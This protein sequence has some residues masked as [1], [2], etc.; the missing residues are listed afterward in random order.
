MVGPVRW[1]P[2]AVACGWGAWCPGGLR[3]PGV[4]RGAG[5]GRVARRLRGAAAPTR[6]ALGTM[7]GGCGCGCGCG[8]WGGAGLPA[9]AW[10][11]CGAGLGLAARG[12]GGRGLLVGGVEHCTACDVCSL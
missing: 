11:G 4:V 1:V 6:A 9:A 5:V 7:A 2:R 10:V 8:G 3:V 12:G